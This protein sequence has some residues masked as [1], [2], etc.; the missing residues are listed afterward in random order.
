[1]RKFKLI[2]HFNFYQ[3]LCQ[4][5]ILQSIYQI[6]FRELDLDEKTQENEIRNNVEEYGTGIKLFKAS[7]TVL[8][9]FDE[10][11]ET[12]NSKKKKRKK[13]GTVFDEKTNFLKCKE[14][15][16]SPRSVL[17]QQDTKHWT[18]RKIGKPFEYKKSKNGTLIEVQK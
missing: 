14:V 4:K 1:M 17:S 8:S 5:K 9:K 10:S 12:E 13:P 16:V 7:S 18:I 15:S 2:C 11:I 3:C 6:N